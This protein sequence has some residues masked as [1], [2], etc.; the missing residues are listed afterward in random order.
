MMLFRAAAGDV[1]SD[2]VAGDETP[3]ASTAGFPNP[4][5]V[6]LSS[7][8]AAVPTEAATTAA[9]PAAPP[10]HTL[11]VQ[12]GQKSARVTNCGLLVIYIQLESLAPD[13]W[14]LTPDALVP[15]YYWRSKNIG[16]HLQTLHNWL[17]V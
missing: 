16:F 1:G 7:S 9:Q 2:P 14:A 10:P 12:V 11:L 4:S 15:K 6:P 17:R 8:L 5:S 13:I 3:G